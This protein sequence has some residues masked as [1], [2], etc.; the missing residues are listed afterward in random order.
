MVFIALGAVAQGDA[1]QAIAIELRLNRQ[2]FTAVLKDILKINHRTVSI[3]ERFDL[4]FVQH[5]CTTS[6]KTGSVGL[7]QH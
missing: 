3:M 7:D 5:S 6:N 4:V 2:T 1:M